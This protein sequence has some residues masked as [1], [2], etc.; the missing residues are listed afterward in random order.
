MLKKLSFFVLTSL[1]FFSFIISFTCKSYAENL[2]IGVID[3]K[4]I[5]HESKYGQ[6]IMK[7]LQKKYDKLSEKIEKKSQEVQ[8]LKE[9]I[10]KKGSLWSK[11]VKKEK[12]KKLQQM[13][14][15]LRALQAE[16]Q[17][18][19]QQEERKLLEPVLKKLEVVL[20]KFVK[21]EKYDLI[22]EK[23][24]P[25]IYYASDRIDITSKIIKL[26]DEYFSKEKGGE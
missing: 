7:K 20:K 4:K 21:K 14:A 9:E 10:E 25:G 15:E 13:M 6:E 16:A 11:K 2:K 5:I 26:F 3:L 23:N 24:Q 17:Y 1:I 8:K 18:E 19:M 22:L 12:E